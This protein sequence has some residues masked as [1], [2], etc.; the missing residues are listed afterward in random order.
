MKTPEGIFLCDD[1]PL[2]D[3]SDAG[4]FSTGPYV[5][6]QKGYL[7]QGLEFM[8][9]A[10]A[11]ESTTP[12]QHWKTSFVDDTGRTGPPF[13]AKATLEDI[14]ECDRPGVSRHGLLRLRKLATCQA[15]EDTLPDWVKQ[16]RS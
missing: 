3:E 1:C 13:F 6:T 8:D 7:S 10:T 11:T 15:F 2:L 14:A 12:V 16:R 5:G 4:R 9:E